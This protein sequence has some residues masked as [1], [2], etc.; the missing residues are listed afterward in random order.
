LAVPDAIN[1]VWS[2]DFMQDQLIDGRSYRLFNVIDD[3]NR[4]CL[5][6]DVDLSL[7]A[8]RVQRSLNQIMKWC[9]KRKQI[10]CDNEPEN[11]SHTLADW[12]KQKCIGLLF[13]QPDNPQQNDLCGLPHV[14]NKNHVKQRNKS[15][16]MYEL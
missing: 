8:V 14:N 10:N 16:L 7:P 15:V 13:I 11:T 4:E 6:I 12:A 2:M 5:T 1:A 9:G 3:F